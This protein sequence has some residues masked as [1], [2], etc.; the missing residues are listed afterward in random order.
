ARSRAERIRR[1]REAIGDHRE[2]LAADVAL[3]QQ[4]LAC[5][6]L[7]EDQAIA[8]GIAAAAN[9]EL[10]SWLVN[11]ALHFPDGAGHMWCEIASHC[12]GTERAVAGALAAL[13]A[14]AE[15]EDSALATA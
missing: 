5:N 4:C 3:Y 9:A 1:E 15:G 10:R 6:E 11:C 8:L 7:S 14:W 12:E 13:S 2:Q